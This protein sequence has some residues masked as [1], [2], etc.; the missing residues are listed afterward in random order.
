MYIHNQGKS[1]LTYL[2]NEKCKQKD[3][4]LVCQSPYSTGNMTHVHF[5]YNIQKNNGIGD[6]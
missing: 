5:S 2:Q 1:L 3:N 6:I 4:S